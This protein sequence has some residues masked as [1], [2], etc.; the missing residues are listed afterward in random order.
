MKDLIAEAANDLDTNEKRAGL[1][2]YVRL[3]PLTKERM[4][5]T[6]LSIRRF[7]EHVYIHAREYAE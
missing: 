2:D 6:V 7:R 1:V 3:R 5:E 4:E